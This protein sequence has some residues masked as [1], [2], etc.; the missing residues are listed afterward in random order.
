M[1]RFLFS[2]Y[3]GATMPVM[4]GAIATGIFE[5]HLG[6]EAEIQATVAYTE[7]NIT[8]IGTPFLCIHGATGSREILTMV[9]G[10]SRLRERHG[11]AFN[12]PGRGSS[13]IPAS[14]QLTLDNIVEIASDMA[15]VARVDR[16]VLLGHGVGT[17]AVARYVQWYPEQVVGAVQLPDTFD[18]GLPTLS[19]PPD[20][21]APKFTQLDVPVLTPDPQMPRYRFRDQLANFM[22]RL[23]DQYRTFV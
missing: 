4:T 12:L 14:H 11:I 5:T 7:Q 21:D 1:I 6:A 16:F 18:E 2:R 23:D 19:C 3:I 22:G 10:R 9:R 15:R 8:G 20:P 17:T 13:A